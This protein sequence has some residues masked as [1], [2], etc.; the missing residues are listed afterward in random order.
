MNVRCTPLYRRYTHGSWTHALTKGCYRHLPQRRNALLERRVGAKKRAQGT[1]AKERLH[2]AERR[3][4]RGDGRRRNALVVGAQLFE[5]TDEAVRIAD[6][7]NA[8][9]VGGILAS[10][11]EKQL[12]KERRKGGQKDHQDSRK[13]ATFAVVIAATTSKEHAK[14][15]QE[16]NRRSDGGGDGAGENVVVAHVREFVSDDAFEFIV[17]HDLEQ[18]LGNR[19]GSVIWTAAGG[20]S[21]GRHIR[22]DIERGNRDSGFCG[23]AFHHLVE[24]GKLLP[25]YGLRAARAQRD[26]VG[27]E[28]GDEVH[29]DGDQQGDLHACTPTESAA[30]HNEK[31]THHD[32]DGTG[33]ND[34]HDVN[35]SGK[36]QFSRMPRNC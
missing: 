5:G 4:A 26:L 3:S 31:D 17:V 23:K 14:P 16:G 13:P 35:L 33:T 22:N 28:V 36:K 12:Q 24:A 20:E 8:G 32:Q 30:G 18:A 21:V 2:D 1:R 6:H 29:D 7:A 15:R 34:L 25:G 9:F 10:S 27:K 19:D 11:G